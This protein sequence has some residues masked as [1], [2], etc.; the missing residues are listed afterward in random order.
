MKRM[1]RLSDMELEVMKALWDAGEDTSRAGLGEKLAD[2][3]WTS[4]TLNTYLARLEEKG[5][6]QVKRAPR[7]NRY[8]PLVAREEY[9]EFDSRFVVSRLYGTPRNFVAA[10][11]RSGLRK[12]E[13][14][15]LRGLLEELGEE[16]DCE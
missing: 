12:G 7:G 1:K 9:L 11:A 15:E 3:H 4:T 14:Q 2:F 10:L 6:V 5:Y 16:T 13:L 8:T